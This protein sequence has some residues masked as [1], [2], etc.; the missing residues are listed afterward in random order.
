MNSYGIPTNGDE[1]AWKEQQQEWMEKQA[2]A[3]I[4]D[5]ELRKELEKAYY[6]IRIHRQQNK[7]QIGRAHV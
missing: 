5:S 2:I 3:L 4:P 1:E 6:Q 7:K